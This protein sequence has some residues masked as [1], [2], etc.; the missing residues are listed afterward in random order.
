MSVT[1]YAY[2]KVDTRWEWLGDE[3]VDHLNVANGNF[4]EAI[5]PILDP[6]QELENPFMGI[7][8]PVKALSRVDG[9]LDA[10]SLTSET[11]TEGRMIHCGRSQEQ[12]ERYLSKL[13]QLCELAIEHGGKL[14]WG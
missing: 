6:K 3:E 11:K 5:L 9:V 10:T 8:C 14:G 4:R 12:V 2:H 13:K 1:F 7:M